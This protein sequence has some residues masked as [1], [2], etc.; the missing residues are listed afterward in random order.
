MP[1][2]P[3]LW[4][5]GIVSC[6]RLG[7]IAPYSAAVLTYAISK[8]AGL[9]VAAYLTSLL[10]LTHLELNEQSTNVELAYLAP[11]SDVAVPKERA[12]AAPAL[13]FTKSIILIAGIIVAYQFPDIPF[14]VPA[15]I[16]LVVIGYFMMTTW[17]TSTYDSHSPNGAFD[18]FSQSLQIGLVVAVGLRALAYFLPGFNPAIALLISLSASALL[19]KPEEKVV[20]YDRPLDAFQW[21]WYSIVT[22]GLSLVCPGVGVGISSALVTPAPSQVFLSLTNMAIEAYT[23]GSCLYGNG[24]SKTMLGAALSTNWLGVPSMDFL[25][26]VPIILALPIVANALLIALPITPTRGLPFLWISSALLVFQGVLMMGPWTL[27]FIAL[28]V[29]LNYVIPLGLRPLLILLVAI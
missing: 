13:L 1:I 6:T 7:A 22:V 5:L 15:L 14:R 11:S 19:V 25:A 3:F 21:G 28:G 9:S 26:A 24:S 20:Y 27:V 17:V 8:D 12:A 18:V 29:F 10:A 4:C 2:L 16:S 23:L